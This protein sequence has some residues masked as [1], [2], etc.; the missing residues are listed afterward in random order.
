LTFAQLALQLERIKATH[1][2]DCRVLSQ[3]QQLAKS[4]TIAGHRRCELND[5]AVLDCTP[6]IDQFCCDLTTAASLVQPVKMRDSPPHGGAGQQYHD[7]NDNELAK[8]RAKMPTTRRHEKLSEAVEDN[9]IG[10]LRVCIDIVRVLQQALQ[11][12]IERIQRCFGKD[13]WDRHLP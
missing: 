8:D 4:V 3:E 13:K 2:G 5:P 7:R 11:R 1:I 9:R 6:G 10:C 12:F